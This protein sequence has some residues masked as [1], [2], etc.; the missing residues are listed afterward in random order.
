M[1]HRSSEKPV[2]SGFVENLVSSRKIV[3]VKTEAGDISGLLYD[4]DVSF[5]NGIGSLFLKVSYGL[6]MVRNWIA[7]TCGRG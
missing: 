6:V 4:Y 5:H 2:M 7:I 1:V 3:T